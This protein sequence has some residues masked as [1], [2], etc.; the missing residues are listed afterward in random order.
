[1]NTNEAVQ[2]LT[3]VV[4]RK[5]LALALERTCCVWLRR[6]CDFLKGLPVHLP[7]EHMLERFVIFG[8]GVATS[9]GVK[10]FT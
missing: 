7:S 4:Q 10:P 5:H 3:E 2:R 1:L 9:P 8:K 6:Y